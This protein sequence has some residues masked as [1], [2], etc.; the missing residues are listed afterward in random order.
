MSSIFLPLLLLFLI[1]RC[2]EK[3]NHIVPNIVFNNQAHNPRLINIKLCI[4]IIAIF[5]FITINI[6]LN[7][8]L[9]G[10]R[11][12]WIV[13]SEISLGLIFPILFHCFNPRVRIFYVRMFWDEAPDWLQKFNPN[14]VVE[15]Q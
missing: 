14:H 8:R 5:L 15:I 13:F 1:S 6:A 9:Y 4:S 3:P 2:H 7:D 10:I 11:G 12:L